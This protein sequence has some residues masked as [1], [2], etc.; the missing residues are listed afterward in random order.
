MKIFKSVKI[1]L[2]LFMSVLVL[3][4]PYQSL[5]ISD[6]RYNIEQA[7]NYD[8]TDC[9]T[10]AT[11]FSQNNAGGA[12]NQAA[13]LS[14]LRDQIAQLLFVRANSEAE[15]KDAV[16]T[17]HVGGFYVRGWLNGD[18]IKA[19]KSS[20]GPAAFVG[21]DEEGGQ[22]DPIGGLPSAKQMG[23]MP[24]D[25]VKQLAAAAGQKMNALGIDVDFA[26]VVD[27]DNPASSAI[28]Q[29]SRS[30]SSNPDVVAEK[31]GAFADGL[32]QSGVT[33]TFKHFP[34][35]GNSPQNSDFD[36]NATTPPL[37]Q[38]KGSD[39]KPYQSLLGTGSKDMVMMS[40]YIVPGLTGS[41]P[42]SLSPAAYDLLR[43]QYHF[44][45]IILTDDLTGKAIHSSVPEAVEKAIDAGA[46]MALFSGENQV[47]PTIDR[48]E[49]KA[50]SDAAFKKKVEDASQKVVQAKGGNAGGTGGPAPKG[51]AYWLGDSLSVGLG[52]DGGLGNKLDTAGYKPNKINADPGRN[53]RS[54][55]VT[56][57]QSGLQ[58]VDA[59]QAFIKDAKVI[60]I[61][62][63]TNVENDFAG[64]QKELLN[65]LH[66]IN[67]NAQYVWVDIAASG[68]PS[69]PD[70]PTYFNQGRP[71]AAAENDAIYTN[72]GAF[73]AHYQVLSQYNFVWGNST[74]P[75]DLGSRVPP[76]PNKLLGPDGVH[77]AGSGYQKL[78]DYLVNG[79]SGGN[80]AG[81]SESGTPGAGSS[82]C[83]PCSVSS[84]SGNGSLPGSI[85]TPYHDIF[86]AAGSKNNVEP[87]LVAA[88]FYAGEHGHSWPNAPPPYGTGPA[89]ASSSAGAQGPFQFLPST[90]S[91]QGQDGNNDGKKD[92]QDLT[93]GAFGAAN[94]LG[95][96]GGHKGAD[97]AGI[98]K[99][100]LAYNHSDAYA[101]TVYKSY[102]EFLGAGG[103]GITSGGTTSGCPGPGASGA[104]ATDIGNVARAE[105]VDRIKKSAEFTVSNKHG[106]PVTQDID[107]IWAPATSGNPSG[108]QDAVLKTLVTILEQYAHLSTQ[109]IPIELFNRNQSPCGDFDRGAQNYGPYTSSHAYGLAMDI[110]TTGMTPDATAKLFKW[111]YDNKDVL[112]IGELEHSP[113]PDG[114]KNIKYGDDYDYPEAIQND[115]K[116]HIHVGV[117]GTGAKAPSCQAKPGGDKV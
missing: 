31:A 95:N 75:K 36:A 101:D 29:L 100:I 28:G 9:A 15:A 68:N 108:T 49:Q 11:S 40:N 19:A 85:P 3:L 71:K 62:L 34:G 115:H 52:L 109:K 102:L 5:A 4:L 91:S 117:K 1:W 37:D 33:P 77:Y 41:D 111:I 79:L 54:G 10:S 39:L 48:L 64:A 81:G 80:F 61:F 84:L 58:A 63:G 55:G 88:I 99:S 38:L 27:L 105:L 17:N 65:K 42:A 18:Q 13:Q 8:K 72:T 43:N 57:H 107:T 51:Q 83:N 23:G 50:N 94:Y 86:I 113:V 12:A 46:T 93:D 67:P 73:D 59:D 24:A 89:W 98:R 112:Q 104:K 78:A 2:P 53:I 47:K 6:Q 66:G 106:N 74:K 90:W 16:G 96:S 87:A 76:D 14:G 25:Q 56:L 44:G 45:G 116:D 30:F 7:F 110:D 82:A 22:I 69:G 97:E 103:T 32:S 35:I 92:I 20:F 21:T 70:G 114:A 60:V 26:P